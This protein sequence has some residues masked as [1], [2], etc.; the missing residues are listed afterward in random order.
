MI[1]IRDMGAGQGGDDTSIVQSAHNQSMAVLYPSGTYRVSSV[2]LPSNAQLLGE[3]CL[4]AGSYGPCSRII[5]TTS[6]FVFTQD[7]PLHIGQM[8]GPRFSDLHLQCANGI[9]INNP[10]NGTNQGA[11]EGCS[12]RRTS[13]MNPTGDGTGIGIQISIPSHF[14]IDDQCD[15]TGFRIGV[16]VYDNGTPSWIRRSRIWQFGFAAIQLTTRSFRAPFYIENNDFLFGF[17]GADSFIKSSNWVLNISGNYMEQTEGEGHG[18]KAALNI[19]DIVQLM[20]L[21]NSITMP[22]ACA[23]NWML[24]TVDSG[25]QMIKVDGNKV[26][27]YPSLAGPALFNGLTTIPLG[28]VSPGTNGINSVKVAYS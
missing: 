24:A 6:A 8:L 9:R 4:P 2:V 23:P 10:A 3:G 27:G 18:M 13:I 19:T 17:Q 11:I 12:L 28:I 22:G 25:A 5:G 16:D 26:V 7:A 1:N 21:N 20:V 14:S 15:I